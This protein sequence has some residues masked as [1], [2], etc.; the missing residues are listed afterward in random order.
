MNSM[1][2]EKELT[3]MKTS[4]PA[5][6]NKPA[7]TRLHKIIAHS[8]VV[9]LREAERLILEGEVTV[10]GVVVDALGANA[11]PVDDVIRVAGKPIPK[12]EE[13]IP[14]YLVAYKPKGYVTTRADEKGRRTVMEL[15][16]KQFQTLYPV[17]RL[18]TNS[19]GLLIFTNDGEF[20]QAMTAPKNRVP[21]VYMVKVRNIPDIKTLKKAVTGITVEGE[22]LRADEVRIVEQK[23]NA[24]WLRVTLTEGKNRHIRRLFEPLGHPVTKLKRISFGPLTLGD[25]KPGELKHLSGDQVN[26]LKK[27][28]LA[29]VSKPEPRTGEPPQ[30]SGFARPE[31]PGGERGGFG[32]PE[33]TGG[34][35]GGF[36]RLERTGERGGF[37]KPGG[38]GR[39]GGFSKPGGAG[40]P[41]GF[42]KPGGYGRT[43]RTAGEQRDSF[44][45]PKWSGG[46][47]GGY[48]KPERTGGYGKPGGFS[49]PGGP[50]RS[51]G[52]GKPGG[53][54]KPGGPPRS[55]RPAGE[56]E[57]FDKPKWS[58]DKPGG[59]GKPGGFSKPGGPARSGGYGKPGGFSKPG[60]PPR[61]PRHAGER[62]SFDKP[63]WSTDKPGGYGKPGGFSKPGG[64]ARSGGP[65][66]GKP[67]GFS[68]PGGPARS[69]RPAGERGSF[70]KPKWSGD[71][72]GGPV[73]SGGPGGKPGGF[74][75]PGG[76]ARS[77]GPGGKP[78]GFSRPGGRPSRPGG[79]KP[80]GFGGKPGGG[81]RGKK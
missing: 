71:K 79:G 20:A 10:N 78:G 16:P 54:S 53:F 60:G 52:Y 51:G 50:A 33:R 73:R 25:L 70:D 11:D 14:T 47:R 40:R 44:D 2:S 58:T 48:A 46:D 36:A 66:G 13:I 56:R 80:G 57:S 59:Y 38:A 43:E 4:K 39:P 64:P 24:A 34:K 63:K 65:G 35:P 72:P 74:S 5:A 1:R 32:K 75:K 9:S 7:L 17:G 12:P 23:G 27:T 42:S 31:R 77:G 28:A 45:K 18:D 30:R 6:K 22:K 37:S 76:P 81:G 62:E 69:P 49:K 68:R 3:T 21:R 19:E 26:R 29:S 8:G 15:L 67:G 61:S 41:G 55:P